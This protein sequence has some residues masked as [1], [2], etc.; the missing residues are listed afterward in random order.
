MSD[1]K[2]ESAKVEVKRLLSVGVIIEVAY[3]EWLANKVMVKNS[4]G[5]WRM[6]ND[7][8]DLNK[9]CPKEA[10]PLTRINSLI[11]ATTNLKLMRLLDCYSGYHQIWM[12]KR[13][14]RRPA[15]NCPVLHIV[16]FGC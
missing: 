15:S 7:F 16:T 6:C 1:D 4:N 5:K 13:M 9:A 2:A 12:K 10:F 3:P 8:I 14:T 11:D